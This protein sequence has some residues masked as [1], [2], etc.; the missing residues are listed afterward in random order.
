MSGDTPVQ[1]WRHGHQ[2]RYYARTVKPG[3][4][5]SD[6]HAGDGA[7]AERT[8]VVSVRVRTFL[9]DGADARS[10]RDR[11]KAEWENVRGRSQGNPATTP[12]SSGPWPSQGGI[13]R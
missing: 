1:Q 7:V 2:R 12:P 4:K 10:R 5:I 13:P 11:L 6:L 8:K 3:L 9:L